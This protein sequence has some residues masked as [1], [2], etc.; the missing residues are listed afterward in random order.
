ML[1]FDTRNCQYEEKLILKMNVCV[2]FTD[3]LLCQLLPYA[4]P[5]C[6]QYELLCLL[7]CLVGNKNPCGVKYIGALIRR[8]EW[9]VQRIGC[10]MQVTSEVHKSEVDI[11]NNGG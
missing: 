8:H 9:G 7:L 2:R 11:D 3:W 10:G 4:F 6:L 5:T 1:Y